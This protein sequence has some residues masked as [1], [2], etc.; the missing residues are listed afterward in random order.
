VATR[1]LSRTESEKLPAG[2]KVIVD[3]DPVELI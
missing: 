3:V 1:L 2:V